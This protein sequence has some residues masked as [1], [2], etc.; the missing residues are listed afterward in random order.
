MLLIPSFPPP[1]DPD[2][3]RP[4]TLAEI[5]DDD[6]RSATATLLKSYPAMDVPSM[7][8]LLVWFRLDAKAAAN[9]LCQD[10]LVR[11]EY[12]NIRPATMFRL[13]FAHAWKADKVTAI[14]GDIWAAPEFAH[15][16]VRADILQIAR[17]AP[18][19]L[20]RPTLLHR[21]LFGIHGNKYNSDHIDS[22]TSHVNT[23]NSY[24]LAKV[25]KFDRVKVAQLQELGQAAG[26]SEGEMV[27]YN[28]LKTEPSVAGAWKLYKEWKNKCAAG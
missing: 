7:Y 18:H 15:E 27:Y 22:I 25:L 5:V 10:V 12:P 8:D 9:A 26:Y 6:L 24:S 11:N 4:E 19:L 28:F 20:H 17:Y 14:L 16:D 2:A 21:L 13:L 3:A 1:A 23:T